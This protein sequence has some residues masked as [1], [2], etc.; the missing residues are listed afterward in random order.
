MIYGEYINRLAICVHRAWEHNVYEHMNIYVYNFVHLPVY[1]S[2]IKG[3][4][5]FGLS[6]KRKSDDDIELT[7]AFVKLVLK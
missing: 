4:S 1:R 3:R 6:E 5:D 2:Y 7:F